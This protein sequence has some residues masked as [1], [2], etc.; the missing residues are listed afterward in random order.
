LKISNG[1]NRL[2]KFNNTLSVWLER[3]AIV[4]VVGMI[5]ATMIDVVGAKLFHWPLP[6]ST[7]IV[8]LF[9]VIAIAGAL[10]ISKIDGRHV[11]IE[12]ID[13]MPQPGRAIISSLVS[14]FGLGLFII[15]CWQSYGY[16]QQF[17]IN[18]EVTANA[19]IIFYP[20]ALWLALCCIPMILILL[21]D[22]ISSLVEIIKR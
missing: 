9:Q 8:Y 13:K 15:L 7:E 20:F 17:R 14:L 1:V 3:V 10:A 22:F 11:R 5:L 6:A 12:F 19:R 16:A 2:E 18:K 4:A 21:K